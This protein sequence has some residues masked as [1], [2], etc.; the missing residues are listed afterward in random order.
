MAIVVQ[1]L[2]FV[3][4]GGGLLFSGVSF[5]VGDRE[6]ASLVG[7]NGVGKST[8]LRLLARELRPSQGAI[9]ID[10]RLQ[11]MPQQVNRGNMQTTVRELLAN[12]SPEPQRQ[13]AVELIEAERAIQTDFSDEAGVRF[14]EAIAHWG[15]GGGY[16]LEGGW[17]RCTCAGLGQHLHEVGEGPASQL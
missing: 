5:R 9:Q 13:R 16:S 17:D 11:Y 15:E 10:G 14:G 7:V 2:E 8:L 12:V 3:H 4:P 6:H 1:D